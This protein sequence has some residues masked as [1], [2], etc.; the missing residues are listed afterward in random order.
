[1]ATIEMTEDQE[2]GND[3]DDDD[4]GGKPKARSPIR[5]CTIGK[6]ATPF[7]SGL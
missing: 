4:R 7:L 5:H 2:D 6:T 1:V 3:D